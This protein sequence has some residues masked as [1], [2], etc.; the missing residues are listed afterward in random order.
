MSWSG[1][2]NYTSLTYP[3]ITDD[4]GDGYSIGSEW[5][6]TT[7]SILFKCIDSTVGAAVW[8]KI[9]GGTT[10]GKRYIGDV[11]E[12]MVTGTE[13]YSPHPYLGTDARCLYF[14]IAS[15]TLGAYTLFPTQPSGTC[16]DILLA[17]LTMYI[18]GA[19]PG[20]YY[21]GSPMTGY[22]QYLKVTS[23]Q[24]SHYLSGTNLA[25]PLTGFIHYI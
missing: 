3:K 15:P 25:G 2:N 22:I 20:R 19:N 5:L 24:I 8:V 11:W 23:N 1:T 14:N 17:E 10:V 6:W 4:A 9:S 13:Y 18:G 21:L 7:E 16:T 12:T